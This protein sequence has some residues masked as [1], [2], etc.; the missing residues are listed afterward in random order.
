MSLNRSRIIALNSRVRCAVLAG[1]G[2]WLRSV[3]L[4]TFGTTRSTPSDH[5]I[6]LAF[7]APSA[8]GRKIT[9]TSSDS[10]GGRLESPERGRRGGNGDRRWRSRTDARW[11]WLW[12]K[13]VETYLHNTIEVYADST[14]L[15]SRPALTGH[16]TSSLGHIRASFN[17]T[18]GWHDVTQWRKLVTQW[19]RF[20]AHWVTSFPSVQRSV[21]NK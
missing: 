19:L 21:I 14:D 11:I 2:N 5:L 17:T 9:G 20:L 13:M 6:A 4:P 1:S 10:F 18:T 8:N 7:V 12:T 16:Q 15:P 3:A